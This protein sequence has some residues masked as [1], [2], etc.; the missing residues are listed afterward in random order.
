MS[1]INLT[2]Y[3]LYNK[4]RQNSVG[5]NKRVNYN[6][7]RKK[8]LNKA[9]LGLAIAAMISTS[10]YFTIKDYE[11]FKVRSL[12]KEGR[13]IVY[14]NTNRTDNNLYYYYEIDKIAEA[15]TKDPDNFDAKLYGVYKAIGYNDENKLEQ[16]E[17][18]VA[19]V[20]RIV[21]REQNTKIDYYEGFI[22]YLREK[23][24]VNKE[25]GEVD[26]NT[27]E[28]SMDQQILKENEAKKR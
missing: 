13:Q 28:R 18:V 17:K 15:L 27:Y 19:E 5:K 1:E 21:K 9:F 3:V 12:V 6:Q 23:G 7:K 22:H 8:T 26:V 10:A 11:I 2:N 14:D 20:G 24:F 4:S 16:M 25:N